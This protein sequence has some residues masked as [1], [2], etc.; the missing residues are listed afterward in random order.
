[1]KSLTTSTTINFIGVLVA[2]RQAYAAKHTTLQTRNGHLSNKLNN[3][4]IDIRK[5]DIEFFTRTLQQ[6]FP[7][8]P[9][10]NPIPTTP[11]PIPTRNPRTPNPT[12][13]PVPVETP[14]PTDPTDPPVG[15]ITPNPTD[16]VPLVCG[17]PVDIYESQMRELAL[18]I[19]DA[20]T[21][22]N[23]GSPQA[24]ALNWLLTEDTLDPPVCPDDGPCGARQR[25][26]MA[27]FY[28][29]SGGGTWD[30]CN[31]PQLNTAGAIALA[32]ANCDRVVTPFPVN[33]PRIGA[34]STDA[35][36][37]GVDECLWG[38]LACWG[39]DDDRN[40]KISCYVFV[41]IL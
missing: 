5:E 12:D 3:K 26:I 17:L 14:N 34:T 7:P 11:A 22:N 8:T 32:N 19:T 41:H 20:A 39:T 40:G 1:M 23:Q 18:T 35:W 25:Y 4:D 38:G 15:V 27:S 10:P 24:K 37:T 30:Q 36:L 6:S 21:L 31:A 2:A 9:Q 29:A 13:P 28:Y 33:N 16:P